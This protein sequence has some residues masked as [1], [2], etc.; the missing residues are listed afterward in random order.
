MYNTFFYII[1]AF[2][3]FEAVVDY[4]LDYLNVKNVKLTL[5]DE[6]KGIYNEKKYAEQQ[7][8]FK[9]NQKVSTIKGLVDFVVVF[10]LLVFG[11]FGMLDSWLRT[12]TENPYWLM[13]MFFGILYV[14]NEILS[15]PFSIYDTFVVEEKFGFNKTTPKIFVFDKI[16][17]LLLGAIIGG[18]IFSLLLYFYML[19]PQYF[20]LLALAVVAAFSIF[21]MMFYS[22]II[23]PLFN[24]QTPLEEGELRTAIEK[25][26]DKAG[27]KLNNIYV[28]DGSKRS[29]KANAY[30]TGLGSKKRIVLYDTLIND[31]STEEIVAV[32]AH[33]VGHYKHKHTLYSLIFSLIVSAI[34]FYI[35]SLF[36]GNEQLALALGGDFASFHL[37]LLGF[38]LLFT[39]ISM[40]FSVLTNVFS[41][42]NE[43]QADA[44]AASFGLANQLIEG[45]KKLS[46]KSLSNLLPHKAYVFFYY[47][48]PTLLQR[49]KALK[50]LD[51]NN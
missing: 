37:S 3:V 19:I 43:Y 14:A 12:F 51:F 1:I 10:A 18:G 34:E 25:F 45:L 30:F 48:H 2:F 50:K 49:I 44:F 20:W 39:P 23:V 31:L 7:S 21:F 26:A 16:K 29:T 27:F 6:L 8:Y 35:L 5:P 40:V 24:K 15:L 9:L 22:N 38:G 36:L 47:S 32:L 33:E 11:V 13:L 28:I 41:R 42:R 17:G 4:V 46:V